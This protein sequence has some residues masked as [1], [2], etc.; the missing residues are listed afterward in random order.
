MSTPSTEFKGYLVSFAVSL[1]GEHIVKV[2][3]EYG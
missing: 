3:M 2:K 1:S